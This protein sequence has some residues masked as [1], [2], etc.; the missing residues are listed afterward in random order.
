[1]S[2]DKEIDHLVQSLGLIS[3]PEGG[4]FGEQYR[5]DRQ[6]TFIQ[7]NKLVKLYNYSNIHV[8]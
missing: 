5:T 3:H 2:A 4:F 8:A 1:M 6:V 7:D